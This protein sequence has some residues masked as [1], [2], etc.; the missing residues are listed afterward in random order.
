[1]IS[2]TQTR[3]RDSSHVAGQQMAQIF[4]AVELRPGEVQ[5]GRLVGATAPQDRELIFS[6]TIHYT[7]S[8]GPTLDIRGVTRCD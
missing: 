8:R 1:M 5:V 3:F 6:Y 7:V 2:P 4:G